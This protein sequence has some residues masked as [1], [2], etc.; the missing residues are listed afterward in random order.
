MKRVSVL[1]VVLCT[2]VLTPVAALAVNHD[3]DITVDGVVNTVDLLWALQAVLGSRTLTTEQ[4]QH[5]DVAPLV[6]GA[7]QPDGVFNL[8]DVVVITRLVLGG[9]VFSVPAPPANQFNI[10]DSIGEGEAANGTIGQAHHENVWS[11]GYAGGDGVNAFNER[12]ESIASDDYYENNSGRD[13]VFNK[14]VSGAVMSDFSTQAQ[15]VISAVS[16]TPSG[17]AGRVA[18]LLG[19]NDVCADSLS[20]MTDPGLFETRYRAGLDALAASEATRQAQIH[21][22]GIPAIYWLWN[23]KR[24]D[25]VCR[26]FI[27]PFVPCQNLL[28]NPADDC[29]SGTS[30]NDPDSDYPGDGSNC[31]RRK[32]FHR[33]IRDTYNPIL[34]DVLE[35]Y[36][37]SGALPNARYIDI[38]DVKFGSADVNGGDCFHP[39][40]AG[41]ALLADTEWCRTALGGS[42]PQCAN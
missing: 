34:R 2:L 4:E 37:Q 32:Q 26:V 16:Q 28:D 15:N 10:G 13:P 18:V 22:S 35:E 33:I 38:Y 19:N 9:L 21:V 8:G 6:A 25:F 30:R 42:D 3:G 5:G 31:R 27:W 24:S 14:A 17:K 1:I 23:A 36:R 12:Y 29:A 39:S 41:H 11:T 7:P 20:A 40:K